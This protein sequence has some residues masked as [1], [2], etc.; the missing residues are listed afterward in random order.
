MCDRNVIVGMFNSTDLLVPFSALT[1]YHNDISGLGSK[2]SFANGV[3]AAGRNFD[4]VLKIGADR[5]NSGK[6][7][8][9]NRRS[10]FR[11]WVLVGHPQDVSKL[12]GDCCQG[13]SLRRV[14]VT[15]G[16]KDQDELAASEF[17]N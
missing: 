16:S 14:T 1:R 12:R 4:D 7:L 11:S 9:T 15:I 8:A 6:K 10:I 17:A 13:F 3:A 2:N 5:A